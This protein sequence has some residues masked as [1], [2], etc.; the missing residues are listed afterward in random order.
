MITETI[1]YPCRDCDSENIV[2]NGRNRYGNQQYLCKDC[3]SSRV[4]KP[5]KTQLKG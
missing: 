2:K 3:Q 5:K 1:I 4:L